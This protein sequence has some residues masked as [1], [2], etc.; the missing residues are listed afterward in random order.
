[1]AEESGSS[2]DAGRIE[3][4]TRLTKGF[5]LIEL[6]VTVAVVAI[7]IAIASPSYRFLVLNNRM[8]AQSNEMLSALQLA[9]AE[10]VNRGTRVSVCKSANG[11]ACT[12]A[13]TWA[14]GW[15][16]FIDGGTAGTVDGSDTVLRVFPAL[17]GGS[18]LVGIG[19]VSNFV[20]YQGNGTTTLA[21][22]AVGTI[23]LCPQ[24]PA[25]VAGRD[26]QIT[27]SGRSSVLNPPAT[28]CP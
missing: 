1:M 23:S 9:R 16:V 6:M 13:L 4:M 8:A 20:S 25:T 3:T 15:I 5:T 27:A 2:P 11:T 21:T 17:A 19:N 18:T 14:Q 24:A 22:G 10:A 7:L 12:T 28:A 26:I